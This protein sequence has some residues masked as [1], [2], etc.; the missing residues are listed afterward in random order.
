MK[1]FSLDEE[2]QQDWEDRDGN[3][4]GFNMLQFF[5]LLQD[6]GYSGPLCI[7]KSVTE[8]PREGIADTL[9]YVRAM[10]EKAA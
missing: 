4:R 9:D 7:E 5:G 6:S 1:V 10:M 8:N 2:G 3:K